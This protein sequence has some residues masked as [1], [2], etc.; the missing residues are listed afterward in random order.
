LKIDRT[1]VMGM[2]EDPV[3]GTSLVRAILELADALHLNVVAEGIE[4]PEQLA[5]LRESGCGTGQGFLFAKPS[6]P[7]EIG[8]LLERIEPAV[9]TVDTV[10]SIP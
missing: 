9:T 4:L 6:L 8:S 10:A 3:E 1:F 5:R 2:T 7:D